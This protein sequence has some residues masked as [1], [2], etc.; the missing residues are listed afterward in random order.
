MITPAMNEYNKLIITAVVSYYFIQ[1]KRGHR[2]VIKKGGC[3]IALVVGCCSS[4]ALLVLWCVLPRVCVQEG[5]TLT[6]AHENIL[7]KAT[8]GRLLD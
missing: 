8:E 6:A 2:D 5:L 3:R 4:G 1:K 7:Y